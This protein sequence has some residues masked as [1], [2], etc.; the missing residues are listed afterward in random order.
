VAGIVTKMLHS[1]FFFFSPDFRGS[2]LLLRSGRGHPNNIIQSITM[3][4]TILTLALAAGLTSFAGSAK[5]AV[6]TA[7]LNQF[8]SG[9][10]YIGFGYNNGAIT[11]DY[12]DGIDGSWEPGFSEPGMSFPA[13]G[14][15]GFMNGQSAGDGYY[16]GGNAPLQYG[17][18]IDALV[19]YQTGGPS[20]VGVNESTGGYWAVKFNAGGGNFNY[21]YV[22]VDVTGSG[23]TFG[24]AGVETTPNLA[25]TA[26]A[27]PEPSTYV[28]LGIGAM[29]LLLV[30]RKKK[31]A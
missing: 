4:K 27:V 22:Q 26:G 20:Y 8:T 29:G 13:F 30:L 24:T 17:A 15:I 28:L 14:T 2:Y 1:C 7:N 5:A 21:G 31:S 6:I 12:S 11:S 10:S 16:N 19:S 25:I 23:M 9:S 3:K 18:L